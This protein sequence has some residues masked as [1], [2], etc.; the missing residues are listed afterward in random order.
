MQENYA[1]GGITQFLTRGPDR[2]RMSPAVRS[3]YQELQK[4]ARAVGAR[5]DGQE[6]VAVPKELLRNIAAV[7]SSRRTKTGHTPTD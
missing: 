7:L 5:S 3:L 1:S 2:R 4:Y 6:W